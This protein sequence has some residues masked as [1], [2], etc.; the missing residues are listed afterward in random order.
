MR[1]YTFILTI[2]LFSIFACGEDQGTHKSHNQLK[3]D[4]TEFEINISNGVL[5]EGEQKLVVTKDD[6]VRL[7]IN[8]DKDLV[9]HVHGYDIEKM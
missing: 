2:M 7:I 8:S 3:S 4:K 9:M 1:F 5:S 6:N